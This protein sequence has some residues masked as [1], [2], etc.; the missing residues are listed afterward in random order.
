MNKKKTLLQAQLESAGTLRFCPPA[1]LLCAENATE[2]VKEHVRICPV[3]AEK[4]KYREETLSWESLA[5]MMNGNLLSRHEQPKQPQPGQIWQVSEQYGGWGDDHLYYRAPSVL[6]LKVYP[7]DV[8]RVAQICCLPRLAGEDDFFLDEEEQGFAETW[9]VYSLPSS[10]LGLCTGKAMRGVLP[11]LQGRVMFNVICDE[12]LPEI[13][14]FRRQEIRHSMYFSMAAYAEVMELGEKYHARAEASEPVDSLQQEEESCSPW[15]KSLGGLCRISRIERRSFAAAAASGNSFWGDR[16]KD[17]F[18]VDVK[19]RTVKVD[20]GRRISLCLLDEK[21][22]PLPVTSHDDA[23]GIAARKAGF[24][25]YV[26]SDDC[27][28]VLCLNGGQ[29]FTGKLP[30]R[31]EVH[32]IRVLSKHNTKRPE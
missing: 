12:Q 31:T 18:S 25:E 24:G 15:L 3:C 20:A 32:D 22:E 19:G 17:G 2:E 9:N 29:Y 23:P 7:Y 27:S 5:D 4:L 8:V 30:P 6:V 14:S 16:K 21:G 26:E 28:R 1:S 10:W 13:E 11:R